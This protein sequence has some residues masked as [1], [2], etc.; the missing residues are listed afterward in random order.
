MKKR[1]YLCI[2]LTF[3]MLFSI[4]S[5]SVSA[6]NKKDSSKDFKEEDDSY[7]IGEITKFNKHKI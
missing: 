1:K 5:T 3:V 2:A 6:Y 7:T 4:F